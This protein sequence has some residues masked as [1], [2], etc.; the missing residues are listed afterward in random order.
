[1]IAYR[2]E[3]TSRRRS[4]ILAFAGRSPPEGTPLK[5]AA[6]ATASSRRP[7]TDSPVQ[8]RFH[9]AHRRPTARNSIGFNTKQL[10][11]P[12]NALRP[13]EE[14]WKV[15]YAAALGLYWRHWIVKSRAQPERLRRTFRRRSAIRSGRIRAVEN[16]SDEGAKSC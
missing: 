2:E 1:V 8:S 4:G 5:L 10:T 14:E 16:F 3:G 6:R 15:D 11:T 9:P 12:P 13:D 7:G